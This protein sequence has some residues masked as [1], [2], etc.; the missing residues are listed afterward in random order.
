MAHH[1]TPASCI[2]LIPF[3][4]AAL[5]LASCNPSGDDDG[6]RSTA[7]RVVTVETERV[8]SQTWPVHAFAVGSLE[9]DESVRVRSTV[10]GHVVAIPAREGNRVEQGEELV[11]IDPEIYEL[12]KQRAEA[13]HAERESNYRRTA[14]LFES[15]H[16]S[17][18]DYTAA[19][20]AM[21]SAEADLALARRRLA[22]TKVR[23]PIAGILGRR[24]TSLG[25]Y[26]DS[27]TVLFE[28][29]KSDRLR[30]DFSLP[31]RYLGS[32]Q[33]GQTVRITTRSRPDEV[34]EGT[35]YFVDPILEFATRTVRIR[36][37]IDNSRN[38]LRH[39]LFVRVELLVD[40]I[41]N[42]VVI[43]EEALVSDLSGF[44]VFVVD[45][46]RVA[47]RREIRIGRR[48]DGVIEV[49]EGLEAG[50]RIVRTGHQRLFAGTRI[51]DRDN[52]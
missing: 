28:L 12:E 51:R 1:P 42:A 26:A 7:E 40:E 18:A 3:A 11:H 25:D 24:H 22:D 43:P 34:F 36:A 13:I 30:L 8:G 10:S 48:D 14:R 52:D 4:I 20:S 32:A 46:E 15:R 27:G 23:A 16:V 45:E 37:Y 39:N 41:A 17:E 21:L 50:E 38:L 6:A 31:E 29:V 9:A 5:T 49:P 19:R 2:R 44:S 47:R 33:P 35:V